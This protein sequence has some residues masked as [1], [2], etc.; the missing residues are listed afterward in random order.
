MI[1]EMRDDE[2]EMIAKRGKSKKGKR[3]E[4]EEGRGERREEE[5]VRNK[6]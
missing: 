6:L 2:R 3:K 5:G 1:R 4:R